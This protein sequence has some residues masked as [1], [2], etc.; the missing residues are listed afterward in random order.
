MDLA[1]YRRCYGG[2][3]NASP[4]WDSI[5]ARL[6]ELYGEQEPNHWG[7]IIKYSIGG[8][9]PLD[10]ISAYECDEG[11]IRHAHFCTYGFSSLYYDEESVGGEFSR[12]GF[13][14]TFRLAGPPLPDERVPWPVTLLQ[15]LARSVFETGRWFE[16]NQW[17]STSGPILGGSDTDLVGLAILQDPRLAPIDTPHGR[18]E[19]LQ[20]FGITTEEV[21]Q[22]Q[23]KARTCE[24]VIEEN[25]MVNPLLV[26]DLGRRGRSTR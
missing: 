22:I 23:T 12:F 21:E 19:L 6:R 1:E 20:A 2:P 17:A 15:N 8:P 4:V 11:P 9:D 26:T 16:A 5:S 10:G 25:R 7:S 18:V 24:Q 13:E 14:L 3:H